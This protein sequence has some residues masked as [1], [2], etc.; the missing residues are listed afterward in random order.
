M[1]KSPKR[2]GL[3]LRT[4]VGHQRPVAPPPDPPSCYPH[5]LFRYFLE[6]VCSANVIA[7]KKEHKELRYCNNVLLLPHISYFKLCAGTL[8]KTTDSDFSARND[9]DLYYLILKW[10]S[11]LLSKLAPLAQTSSYAIGCFFNNIVALSAR[12]TEKHQTSGV[13]CKNIQSRLEI[14]NIILKREFL[15][16]LQLSLR[17]TR[18]QL[19]YRF[20][21][22][23]L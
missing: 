14:I 19:S 3:R 23:I 5:H 8:A 21:P 10:R 7:V 22:S 6:G 20:G 9:C 15:A 16:H 1:E 4:P 11:G 13:I 18:H 2:W 12:T 17:I